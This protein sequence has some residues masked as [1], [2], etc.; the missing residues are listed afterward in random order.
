M[1]NG[2]AAPLRRLA[3][4]LADVRRTKVDHVDAL[5][6]IL[7]ARLAAAKHIERELDR[8]LASRFNPLDHLRTA[9]LG[10]SRIV[11]DLIDPNAAHG[12]GF[13]FLRSFLEHI[14]DPLPVGSIPALSPRS[15][16]TRCERRID[17][18]AALA[19][20]ALAMSLT[21]DAACQ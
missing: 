14:R 6:R 7:G 19:T 3:D 2:R 4:Y 21:G 13:L 9:E 16:A 1:N 10:L 17:S 5:F 8:V 18:C 15:V 20:T 11:A 12:Q